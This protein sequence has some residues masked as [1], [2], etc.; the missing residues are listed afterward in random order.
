M[1]KT[2]PSD[3]EAELIV[4]TVVDGNAQVMLTDLVPRDVPAEFFV[5]SK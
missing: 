5:V 1:G 4:G 3:T 2:V